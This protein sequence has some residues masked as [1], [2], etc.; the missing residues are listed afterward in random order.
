MN[1]ACV[2]MHEHAYAHCVLEPQ[3]FIFLGP[4]TSLFD[5][6]QPLDPLEHSKLS[7]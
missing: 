2:C 7:K 1:H 4:K 5:G 3:N 6:S